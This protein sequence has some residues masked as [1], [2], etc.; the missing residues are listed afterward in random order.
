MASLSDVMRDADPGMQPSPDKSVQFCG[1][2][3]SDVA[4]ATVD[5]TARWGPGHNRDAPKELPTRRG[6]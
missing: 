6:S 4:A 2:R 5:A 3:V 1:K